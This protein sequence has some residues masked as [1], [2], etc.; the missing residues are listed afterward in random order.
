MGN[1]YS[2]GP[3]SRLPAALA[4]RPVPRRTVHLDEA[5]ASHRSEQRWRDSHVAGA[6]HADDYGFDGLRSVLETRFAR[7]DGIR[8][9]MK[10]IDIRRVGKNRAVVDVMAACLEPRDQALLD[11]DAVVVCGDGESHPRQFRADG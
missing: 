1:R 8:Y 5:A 2:A 11:G 6:Y 7:A 10:Y 9:T 3:P 4:G